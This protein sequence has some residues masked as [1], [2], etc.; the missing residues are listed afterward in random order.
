MPA[1]IT[2]PNPSRHNSAYEGV[3][4]YNAYCVDHGVEYR[5]CGKLIV[6]TQQG[7]SRNSSAIARA[8]HS[9]EVDDL[10]LIDR[11]EAL[12]LEPNLECAAAL[13]SPSTGII[14]SHAYW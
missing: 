10:R 5:R 3:S 8:A 11:E 4:C 9:N 6:A 2:P 13:I 1:F 7:S 14:D 12:R